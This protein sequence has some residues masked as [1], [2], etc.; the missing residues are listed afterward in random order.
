MKQSKKYKYDIIAVGGIVR[1]MFVVAP[2]TILPAKKI[3]GEKQNYLAYPYGDKIPVTEVHYDLGGEAC[4]A[5]VGMSKCGLKVAFG[6]V[7]GNK[8]SREQ[9]T[10]VLKKYGI[11][12]RYVYNGTQQERGFSLVMVGPDGDRTIFVY[13]EKNDYRK[14]DV[15]DMMKHSASMFVAGIDKSSDFLLPAIIDHMCCNG[16]SLY[17][18]P[19]S[20]QLRKKNRKKLHELLQYTD[21]VCLNLIEAATLIGHNHT[22]LKHLLEQVKSLGPKIV[23]ITLGNEGSVCF[24]GNSFYKAGI[25]KT[26]R[27]DSTGAGDCFFA[28]F[29][30]TYRKTGDI[31]M[32]LRYATINASYVVTGYGGQ[33]PLLSWSQIVDK[34]KKLRLKVGKI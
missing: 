5:A 13:R 4:N 8:V 23:V 1:D 20:Y 21:I 12:D 18:N 9:A 16:K 24:D 22:S 32:A 3:F 11:N 27:V 15:E 26:K 14:I 28:T 25:I 17:V 30:A 19:S 10:K 34:S 7:I 6:A 31:Q 2:A 29:I 33:K